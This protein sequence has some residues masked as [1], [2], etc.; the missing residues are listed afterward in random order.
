MKWM[1]E[2]KVRLERRGRREWKY[3]VGRDRRGKE[4]IASI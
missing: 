2:G 1:W 3:S 4:K